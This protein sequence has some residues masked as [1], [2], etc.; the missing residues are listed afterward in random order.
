[1]INL[2]IR[3][4]SRYLLQFV[5]LPLAAIWFTG[6]NKGPAKETAAAEDP[7]D[8]AAVD[9]EPAAGGK[10]HK[11]AKGKKKK[12]TGKFIG[13]IPIDAWPEVWFKDPL[14]IA[15]EKGPASA[16]TVAPAGDA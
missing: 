14:A 4:P 16:G 1:M 7:S 9:A 6:C 3:L 10:E 11:P 8:E 5:A 12:T 2:R 13:Q 15:A